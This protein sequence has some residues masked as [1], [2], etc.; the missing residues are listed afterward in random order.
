MIPFAINR[1]VINCII[2]HDNY[3]EVSE[4]TIEVEKYELNCYFYLD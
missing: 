3:A 4:I 2:V 1:K